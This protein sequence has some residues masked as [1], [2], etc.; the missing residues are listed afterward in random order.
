MAG[1][2]LGILNLYT[3][4]PQLLGTFIGMIVFAIVEPGKSQELA[5]GSGAKDAKDGTAPLQ[6]GVNAIAVCMFIGGLSSLGA[7]YATWRLRYVR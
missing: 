3:A 4:G 7:A 6:G 1:I 5:G 2:Y